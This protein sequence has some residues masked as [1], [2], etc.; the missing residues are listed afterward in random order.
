MSH[1]PEHKFKHSFQDCLNPLSFC[2]D[3][4]ETS[5][6][7]LL[8]CPTYTNERMTL[9]NNIK[10]INCDIS[11]LKDTIMTKSI[12]FRVNSVS[13]SSNTLTLNPTIDYVIS[14][15]RL[16]DSIL[17]HRYKTK[18]HYLAFSLAFLLFYFW[19]NLVYFSL[20]TLV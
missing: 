8:Q 16:D 13:A 9:L 1:F 2:G 3:D 6:H 20:L 5:N 15:K 12:L 14:T 17:T 11:E 18:K 19:I 4:I 10:N 7:Y